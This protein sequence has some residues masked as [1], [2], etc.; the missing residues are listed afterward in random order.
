MAQRQTDVLPPTEITN[1]VISDSMDST[2]PVPPSTP[3]LKPIT[4]D[5]LE[6]VRVPELPMNAPP[7]KQVSP[8]ITTPSSTNKTPRSEIPTPEPRPVAHLIA[9]L[10]SQSTP[11]RSLQDAVIQGRAVRSQN[12]QYWEVVDNIVA[13]ERER[14]ELEKEYRLQELRQQTLQTSV[15]PKNS[16]DSGKR[17][18]RR[19]RGMMDSWYRGYLRRESPIGGADHITALPWR[20]HDVQQG[21]LFDPVQSPHEVTADTYLAAT[22][23]SPPNGD[24]MDWQS[25]SPEDGEEHEHNHA[26]PQRRASGSTLIKSIK[27]KTK[28]RSKRRD[29]G[30]D[31]DSSPSAA[32]SERHRRRGS[33]ESGLRSKSRSGLG[34]LTQDGELPSTD[35]D[36]VDSIEDD[37]QGDVWSDEVESDNGVAYSLNLRER[38]R[39]G[40]LNAPSIDH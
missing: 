30:N 7:A 36:V 31:R 10:A 11:F 4:M 29:T 25:S 32:A 3:R 13:N 6:P 35:D 5:S 14:V 9:E 27:L 16:T 15:T 2:L 40:L 19:S 22:N 21:Q 38:M 24:E 20:A 12:D 34:G 28:L 26:S 37:G 8:Y 1:T 39:K 17:G 18:R 23:E 33:R